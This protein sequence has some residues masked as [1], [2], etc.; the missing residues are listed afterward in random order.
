MLGKISYTIVFDHLKRTKNKAGKILENIFRKNIQYLK[1][2]P[3]KNKIEKQYI[4][5]RYRED[6]LGHYTT[7]TDPLKLVMTL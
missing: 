7:F 2:K 6:S 1:K 4:V 3:Y 5:V